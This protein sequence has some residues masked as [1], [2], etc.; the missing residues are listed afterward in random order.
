MPSELEKI[1]GLRE[2]SRMSAYFVIAQKPSVFISGSTSSES[3]GPCQEIGSF[4]RSSAKTFSRSSNGR[5]QN[6]KE[7]TFSGE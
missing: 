1:F 2:S 3:G 6:A 5:S 4:A 7:P